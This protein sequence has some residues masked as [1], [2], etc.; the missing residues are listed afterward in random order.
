MVAVRTVPPPPPAHPLSM[1]YAPNDAQQLVVLHGHCAGQ[2]RPL[3][4]CPLGLVRP[5]TRITAMASLVAGASAA[6]A[7]ASAAH[8]LTRPLMAPKTVKPNPTNAASFARRPSSAVRPLAASSAQRP[9][10]QQPETADRRTGTR[11]LSLHGTPPP[12][13]AGRRGTA[14][15]P[16]CAP[17]ACSP[18]CDSGERQ[19]LTQGASPIRR[20]LRP[21]T[22]GIGSRVRGW[23]HAPLAA[24]GPIPCQHS[25]DPTL[26]APATPIPPA[27]RRWAVGCRP[28]RSRTSVGGADK[29]LGMGVGWADPLRG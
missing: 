23:L 28:H 17:P 25:L 19:R 3:G 18:L 15:R 22:R 26:A 13:V 2:A 12:V 24:A 21:P 4:P 29:G 8:R 5:A 20:P 9:Q 10:P 16:P 1:P 6:G 11:A 27:P 14:R 7:Q